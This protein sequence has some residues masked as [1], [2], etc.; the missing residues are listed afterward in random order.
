MNRGKKFNWGFTAHD[1][2]FDIKVGRD[3]LKGSFDLILGG[4]HYDEIL[5]LKLGGGGE[6]LHV[7]H[8][9]KRGKPMKTLI[10]MA[11][12]TMV[13]MQNYF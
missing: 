6:G 1:W 12:R 7:K 2:N 3:A 11:Y 5:M 10:E 13:R 8:A 9:A 4:I